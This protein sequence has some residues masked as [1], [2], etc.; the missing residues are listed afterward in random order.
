MQIKKGRLAWLVISILVAIGYIA[1]SIYQL[2]NNDF[3][4]LNLIML[5]FI[6]DAIFNCFEKKDK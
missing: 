2:I 4:S 6:G 5:I 1:I 3:D